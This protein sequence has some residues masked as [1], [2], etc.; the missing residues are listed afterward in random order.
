MTLEFSTDWFTHNEYNLNKLFDD[1]LNGK[2][3]FLVIGSF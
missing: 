1:K 2:K 3:D